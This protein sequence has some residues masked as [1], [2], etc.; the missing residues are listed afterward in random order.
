MA[1]GSEHDMSTIGQIMAVA[2]LGL[3][4]VAIGDQKRFRKRSTS[5]PDQ[6]EAIPLIN[7]MASH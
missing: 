3:F 5:H 4:V 6:E 7:A 1:D 2:A